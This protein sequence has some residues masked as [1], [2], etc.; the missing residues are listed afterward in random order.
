MKKEINYTLRLQDWPVT[1]KG[2]VRKILARELNLSRKEISRLKFDGEILLNGRSVRVNDHMR[3]GDTLTLRFPESKGVSFPERA[4]KPEILYEDEDVVVV[5]KPAGI[6]SHPVHGHLDDSMGSILAAYYQRYGGDFVIRPIGRLDKDVSGAAVYGKNRPGAARL[7]KDLQYGKMHKYYTAFVGGVLET[8]AGFIDEPITKV[9]YERRRQTG[10]PNGKPARTHYRVTHEF[11]AG[12]QSVSVLAVEIETGRTHQIRAHLASIG[13]PILG[14]ELYGGDTALISRPALHC[15]RVDFMTPFERVPVSVEAPLPDDMIRLLHDQDRPDVREEPEEPAGNTAELLAMEVIKDGIKPV[16]PVKERVKPSEPAKIIPAAASEQRPAV[17]KEE[18]AVV[19]FKS[20][21]GGKLGQIL[22]AVIAGVVILG[23]GG[24]F[25]ARHQAYKAEQAKEAAEEAEIYE[26]L[27]V[28]FK[29]GAIVEYGGDFRPEDYVI[30]ANGKLTVNGTVDTMKPGNQEVIYILTKETT[31]GVQVR[32]D[33]SHMFTVEDVI[34]PEI[35]LKE[36]TVEI[37]LSDSYDPKQNVISAKDP[38]D[39]EVEYTI[40][41]SG[42]VTDV[43]GSYE[44]IVSAK[45]RSGNITEKKFTVKVNEKA[46]AAA[47]KTAKPKQE[48]TKKTEEAKKTPEP[49]KEAPDTVAP[50]IQ[51]STDHVTITAGDEFHAGDFI[52]SVADDKDGAL[53][54]ADT[55]SQGSYTVSSDVNPKEPGT[56]EVTVTAVD[57]AGNRS[58]T[59]LAVQVAKKEPV[60]VADSSNP[61]DQIYRFLRDSMGFTKAQACGILANIHRESRFN[62]NSENSLGYYG[63]CQWGYERKENLISWC[64]EN[65]YDYTTIDGQLHF[66]QYEMPLYYPNTTAQLRAVSDDE[67]GARR[68]CWIFS[69]GYE[70]SGEE[71]ANMSMDKASEYYNE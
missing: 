37:E 35:F 1:D 58:G 9:E 62:P 67:E 11:H 10:D 66:L 22:P 69:I 30:S 43:P 39:G 32:K 46:A 21:S 28:Q 7:S 29:D 70:V 19:D 41:D 55:L 4:E 31:G 50:V 65:D 16:E 13:F 17:A 71:L 25:F 12:G 59:V 52:S 51:L 56:Y 42:L 26:S 20:D 60:I 49:V 54:Y 2:S 57:Q 53:P 34:G 6:V 47:V 44:V 5:N 23:A 14:D 27:N 36:E 40:D 24:F 68:A 63:L 8:R 15:A 38:V 33:F 61:K 48:E 3:I 45:D 64:E 18:A